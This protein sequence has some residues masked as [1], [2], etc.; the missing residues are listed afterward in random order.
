MP[1]PLVWF[2]KFHEDKENKS[3]VAKKYFT[4][5]G[6]VSD[7][8]TDANQKYV[9]ENMKFSDDELNAAREAIAANF[10]RGQE[11]EAAAPGSVQ[12]RGLATTEAGDEAASLEAIDT[13]ANMTPAEDAVTLDEA[14]AAHNAENPRAPR[15]K[16][17]EDEASTDDA[18][19]ESETSEVD[20]EDLDDLLD[21]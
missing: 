9:V 17:S 7:I 21:D 4:T 6:K 1:T 2:L 5:P 12:K 3:A 14:R 13:I 8:Q 18:V 19:S 16:K 10:V 20:E 15:A 11:A